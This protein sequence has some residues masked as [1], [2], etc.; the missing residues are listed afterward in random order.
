[1]ILPF[2]D[3]CSLDTETSPYVDLQPPN[4]QYLVKVLKKRRADITLP[5]YIIY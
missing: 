4:D 3:E 5:Y 1:M 2:K